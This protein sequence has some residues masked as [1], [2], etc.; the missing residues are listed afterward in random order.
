MPLKAKYGK[1]E[2]IPAEVAGFYVER[3]GAWHLDAE[4]VVPKERLDEFRNTNIKLAKEM[5]DQNKRY[6]GI[7]P[8]AVRKLEEEK[9]K[10][11]ELL[12]AKNGDVDKVV[13]ARIKPL[14]DQ[15][16]TLNTQLE[17]RERQLRETQVNQEVI[18][19][20]TKKGLR[21][22]AHDDLILR[23]SRAVKLE[24][25]VP[26][27]IDLAT[28][29]VRYG[30]DGVTPMTLDAWVEDLVSAAP[31]LFENNSGSGAAGNG[32]GGAG[33][34]PNPWKRETRNITK[35]GE[36]YRKDPARARALASAAGVALPA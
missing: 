20:A 3:E 18:T 31:H 15:L 34:E 30:P 21:P 25:G 7:D 17:Q 2:E 36:I 9:R 16:A 26:K 19:K 10:A 28:G 27:V 29:Q 14:Q 12:A 6:A 23:A 11:E 32:S 35:Q 13:L 8:E 33:N 1:K 4:G 5:E 22:S 24:N